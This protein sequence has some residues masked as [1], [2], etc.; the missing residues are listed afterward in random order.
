MSTRPSPLEIVVVGAGMAAQRF[1]ARLVASESAPVRVT[2]I[3]DENR[4]PYDRTRLRELFLGAAAGDLRLPCPAFEDDRV[5]VILDD[6]VLRIDRRAKT[7]RTR[8]RRVYRYDMLVLATGAYSARVAVEGRRCLGASPTGRST[9]R[10]IC[11]GSCGPAATNWDALSAAWSSAVVLSG[12]RRRGRCRRWGSPRP[13][14]SM[15]SD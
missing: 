9:T 14:S 3:G 8:S 12:S 1:V 15:R 2:V 10:K 13:S 4:P 5:S 7:V 11:D 6:R